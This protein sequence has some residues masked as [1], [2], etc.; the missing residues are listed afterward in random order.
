[1]ANAHKPDGSKAEERKPPE[2]RP[3]QEGEHQRRPWRVEGS[4][5]SPPAAGPPPPRRGFGL[6]WLWLLLGVMLVLN[7]AIAGTV[8]SRTAP[9]RISVPYS[10]FH[11]QVLDGNVAQ[12][13]A[14]GQS[15]QGTLRK[16]ITYPAGQG[17][18][19]ASEFKTERPIFANDQ[20]F[21]RLLAEGATVGAKPTT[22]S[23]PAWESLLLGFGPTLLLV[24]LFVLI[25]RGASRSLAGGAGSFSGFGKARARRYEPTEQRTTFKDVAGIDEATE[26]L[27]EVVDFLKNP[28]RYRALG[29][30][31]PRGVLLTGPPG[32]GKTLLAKAVAGEA[33]VPFFS[34]SASEFIEM[35]VGVGASRV[36]DLFEQAK[37]EAPAIVFIDELDAIGRSRAAGSIPGGGHDER[38]QTLNQVLTE[39]DGFTGNEGVIV[40]AATNRPEI[41]DAALLRPG[42]FDRRVTVNPPDQ[43]G[44]EQILRVHS[45]S[46]PLARDVD[47][48]AVAASTPGMVGAD[49]RNLVNEAALLAAR[50]GRKTVHRDDF[51]D[52]L[53]KIVLGAARNIL[54][55]PE[56]RER[57]AYH[58]A[59]HALLGMLEPGA[60]PVRKISIIPR[61]RAL[62]V[63]FQSPEQDRYGFDERYLRGRMTGLLGGRAAEELIYGAVTTGAESDLEQATALARQMVGRWGMSDEIGLVTVLAAEG[64]GPYGLFGEANTSERTRQILDAEV[65]KIADQCH[66]RALDTLRG[67]REQLDSLAHALLE[68]ETLDEPDAYAAAGIPHVESVVQ[69]SAKQPGKGDAGHTP[70]SPIQG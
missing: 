8:T 24:G 38:E 57:T 53:E 13:T 9:T 33:D 27:A 69:E 36:R 48:G 37:R 66:E 51:A 6:G 70:T 46:V 55:S 30:Q 32:T 40:L 34:M 59:G 16:A 17:G 25:W 67:H 5:Q 12:V 4:R 18:K 64:T 31:V 3:P 60:D 65:R 63:T 22:S 29:A 56:E 44:R 39:M 58:E 49:L 11:T 50:R 52:A 23:T 15:I 41:L 2:G 68:H 47:L 43:R 21:Q 10:V 26:D 45:R 54:I 62:G 35:I 61:G 1:M 28:D 14:A 19:T 42:R 7:W 20:I